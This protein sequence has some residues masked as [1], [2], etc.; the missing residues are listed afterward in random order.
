MGLW[1]T[2]TRENSVLRVNSF[3]PSGSSGCFHS[4]ILRAARRAVDRE[5]GVTRRASPAGS[6]RGEDGG[7]PARFRVSSRRSIGKWS[8]GFQKR[9]RGC[10]GG[11]GCRS[12][13]SSRRESGGRRN[14]PEDVP[15]EQGGRKE[16]CAASIQSVNAST[17]RRHSRAKKRKHS[18]P[19]RVMVECGPR[20]A[21]VGRGKKMVICDR[22]RGFA[23]DDEARVP[24]APEAVRG[25]GGRA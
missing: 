9:G 17:L 2:T 23:V 10:R 7:R 8:H 18:L 24:A 21:L 12:A 20:L 1:R 4:E 14:C 22:L 25:R 5:Q 19:Q 15:E 11:G 16:K 6:G 3:V 13:P